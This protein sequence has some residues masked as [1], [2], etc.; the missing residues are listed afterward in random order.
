MAAS[1]GYTILAWNGAYGTKAQFVVKDNSTG[2]EALFSPAR[3]KDITWVASEISSDPEYKN[4]KDFGNEQI[5]D[6]SEVVF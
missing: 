6:L 2:K 4:W 5:S 3:S 1:K